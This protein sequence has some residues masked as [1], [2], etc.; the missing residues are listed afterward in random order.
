MPPPMP[1]PG[2]AA[3]HAAGLLLGHLGDHGFVVTSR[4]ATEAASCSA[5]RT[6][7]VGSM[8]PAWTQVLVVL[9]LGVEAERVGRRSPCTLPTTI[10]PSTPEFW[11]IWR[12]GLSAPSGRS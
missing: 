1:P 9:Q 4:P 5:V 12:I 8:M 11:A 10:E 2:H 3:A 6:T 7:L